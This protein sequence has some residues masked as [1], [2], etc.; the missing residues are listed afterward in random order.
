MAALSSSS[1]SPSRDPVRSVRSRRDFVVI[2]TR[3]VAISRERRPALAKMKLGVSHSWYYGTNVSHLLDVTK[4]STIPEET[5]QFPGSSRFQA[6]DRRAT[7]PHVL[8]PWVGKRY[9]ISRMYTVQP[10]RIHRDALS[11][12][13]TGS[14]FKVKPGARQRPDAV[15]CDGQGVCEQRDA[16]PGARRIRI[17]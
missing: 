12:K 3:S 8:H 14:S 15:S 16:D 9:L 17:G 2:S 13:P 5:P 1:I 6:T 10:L 4:R 11:R 7:T